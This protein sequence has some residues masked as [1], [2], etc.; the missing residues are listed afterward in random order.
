MPARAG[1]R[2]GVVALVSLLLAACGG[3]ADAVPGA[4][5]ATAPGPAISDGPSALASPVV[6]RLVRLASEGLTSVTG[7]SLRTADGTELEFRVGILENG[8]EFPPGHLAEHM[9]LGTGIRVFFRAE[10]GQQVVYRVEDAE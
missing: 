9:A 5:G 2:A 4:S 8:A 3:V 6:G 7:F 1:W 10:D